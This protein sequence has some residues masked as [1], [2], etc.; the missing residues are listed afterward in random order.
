ML[1][2]PVFRPSTF[3]TITFFYLYTIHVQVLSFMEIAVSCC[4]V[5]HAMNDGTGTKM[6]FTSAYTHT[7]LTKWP[8]GAD[9]DVFDHVRMHAL[10]ISNCCLSHCIQ[11]ALVGITLGFRAVCSL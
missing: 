7:K 9:C 6:T 10:I 8:S 4:Y 3:I 5:C 2:H 11:Y 1:K